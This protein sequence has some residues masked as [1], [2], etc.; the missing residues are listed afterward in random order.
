MKNRTHILS[1][2]KLADAPEVKS[3]A[4]GYT[5]HRILSVDPE[6]RTVE[7]IVSTAALDSYRESVLPEAFAK[8]LPDRF[9]KNAPLLAGHV[10][11]A[12]DGTPGKIGEWTEMSVKTVEGVGKALVGKATIFSGYE[13]ADTCWMIIS[14]S[15][16]VAFSVGWLTHASELR[17]MD[18]EGQKTKVRVYTDVE[19]VEVSFVTV[20]ANPEAVVQAS[21][22]A[23]RD[24]TVAWGAPEEL[25]QFMADW[26]QRFDQLTQSIEELQA[27]FDFEPGSKA[28][29]LVRH[30]IRQMRSSGHQEADDG[31]VPPTSHPVLEHLAQQ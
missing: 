26:N 31:G 19:L 1:N 10:Y 9:N 2:G 23:Q 15:K 7:A 12:E 5:E 17:E 30:T 29:E 8:R 27:D 4:F 16:S 3:K 6:T 14:Q 20:P 13:L 28:H 22:K 21:I 25:A 18:V 24:V 11:H